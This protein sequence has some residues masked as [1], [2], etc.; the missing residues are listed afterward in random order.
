MDLSDLYAKRFDATERAGKVRIWGVLWRQVFSKWIRPQDT[1]LDVGAGYCEFINAVSAR[2]R[3]A[4]D[5]NP[6][7]RTLAAP[8]I[9]VHT[10]SAAELSFLGDGEV[11]VAFTSN[12]FEH[13]PTKDVL[14]QVVRATWRVLRPGGAFI[15]MGPNIRLLPGAY[16]DFYDHQIPL[17][18]RSVCELLTL[19][20]FEIERVEAGFLPYTVKG[21]LP[22]WP[23][24]VRLY[25]AL[26]P[27]SSLALG[28]QFLVVAR[29]PAEPARAANDPPR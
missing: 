29:R 3:I 14:T 17:S 2:R 24:L 21:L 11:D 16:W 26:R 18:D 25:L 6:E 5:L 9:E 10:T 20:G 4:V 28:K 23:V 7:T 15:V 19:C 8:G 12:F 1:V 27:F 22:P 13:L